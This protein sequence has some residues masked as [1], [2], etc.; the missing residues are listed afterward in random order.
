MI[1][2]FVVGK[3]N[4]DKRNLEIERCKDCQKMTS[5]KILVQSEKQSRNYFSDNTCSAR[6]LR[7]VQY[8]ISV[9]DSMPKNGVFLFRC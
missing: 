9:F 8:N 5:Q 6:A 4:Q 2:R 3:Q 7:R 1:R